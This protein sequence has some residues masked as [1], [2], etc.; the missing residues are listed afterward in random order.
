MS[1]TQKDGKNVIQFTGEQFKI[2]IQDK[3]KELLL[4]EREAFKR[5]IEQIEKFAKSGNQF[6]LNL[7]KSKLEA[8]EKK[9]KELEKMLQ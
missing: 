8:T 9:I 3:V 7:Y 6:K 1:I 4:K 5:I 2:Q